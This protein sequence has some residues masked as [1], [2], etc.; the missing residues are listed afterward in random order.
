MSYDPQKTALL[1]VDPYNDF[2]GEGGKLFSRAKAVADEV[3]LLCHLPEIVAI[4]RKRDVKVF[5]VPH[6]RAEPNDY[7]DWLHPS[8]YQLAS[9]KGQVFAKNSWGGTFH[10]DFKAQKGD[11]IIKEHWAYA[12]TVATRDERHSSDVKLDKFRGVEAELALFF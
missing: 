4:A 2:L 11:V 3:N 9:G 10:D 1:L 8:P 7:H 6:H 5:F 12:E